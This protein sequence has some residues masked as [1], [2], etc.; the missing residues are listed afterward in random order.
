[1][2]L[3]E[4]GERRWMGNG[5]LLLKSGEWIVFRNSCQKEDWRLQDMFIGKA[6]DGNWYYSTYHFC[7]QMV[8]LSFMGQ[9]E[10]LESFGE[11]CSV[12]QFDGSDETELVKTFPRR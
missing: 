3:G 1:M 10:D 2:K 11:R 4:G 9:P 12:R 7:K 8:V 6:S 5:I